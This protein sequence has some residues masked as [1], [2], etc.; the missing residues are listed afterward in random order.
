VYLEGN[1]AE[2]EST[3]DNDLAGYKRG[4]GV[5]MDASA[6]HT[7]VVEGYVVEGHVPANAIRTLIDTRPAVSGLAVPGMPV[8]T[9][10]MGGTPESWDSQPVLVIN[11]DGSLTVFDY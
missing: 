6:C 11:Q 7:A 10:G 1:G 4:L 2:V 5:P 3:E 8:D 9:P